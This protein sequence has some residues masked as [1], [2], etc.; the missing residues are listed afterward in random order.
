[1]S[2]NDAQPGKQE[3]KHPAIATLQAG[4][5]LTRFG[6]HLQQYALLGSSYV[7]DQATASKAKKKEFG[8]AEQALNTLARLSFDLNV[9]D[10]AELHDSLVDGWGA[11]RIKI[12]SDTLFDALDNETLQFRGRP[13]HD[14]R[15]DSCGELVNQY[16]KPLV[17][18]LRQDIVSRLDGFQRAVFELGECVEEGLCRRDVFKYLTRS[19]D[20][21]ELFDDQGLAERDRDIESINNWTFEDACKSEVESD[22]R[23]EPTEDTAVLADTS[24][25]PGDLAPH[26]DW[27]SKL[28]K[29][30]GRTGMRSGPPAAV[31][32]FIDVYNEHTL[33]KEQLRRVV[34][35]LTEQICGELSPT[36]EANDLC[37]HV[38]NPHVLPQ[39]E[40]RRLTATFRDAAESDNS[41][42]ATKKRR[43][44]WAHKNLPLAE[45]QWYQ[46]PIEGSL[47]Y[48]AKALDCSEPTVKRMNEDGM[49]WVMMVH[50][51]LFHLFLKTQLQYD[52]V[53]NKMA[54]RTP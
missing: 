20:W 4:R 46:T 23:A 18:Q 16:V 9:M 31:K 3:A 48:L 28:L 44:S 11:W 40:S 34:T 36:T 35:A 19:G 6:W 10:A 37:G 2:T 14:R 26:P 29:A 47:K 42:K 45:Y 43:G 27:P 24:R 15:I 12:D 32:S 38:D 13:E 54:E 39:L 7:T 30:W 25:K 1:M 33:R 51:K 49:V 8:L 17:R 41:A 22:D 52:Q 50:S 53:R 21:P 5:W